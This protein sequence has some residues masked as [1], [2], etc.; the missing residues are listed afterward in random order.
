MS[1]TKYT[2]C[3]TKHDTFEIQIE[4]CKILNT[5]CN[6]DFTW[7]EADTVICQ[8]EDAYLRFYTQA[9]FVQYTLTSEGNTKT[10]T[11][12]M[13][14]IPTPQTDDIVTI[15]L[16]NLEGCDTMI[17]VGIHVNPPLLIAFL[18]VDSVIC[19]DEVAQLSLLHQPD[20]LVEIFP[21][22]LSWVITNP[23]WP[24]D[25][26][27]IS[28]DTTLYVRI[29][30]PLMS[31]D[32]FFTW[33]IR[34]DD[35]Q[36]VNFDTI[37]ICHGDSLEIDNQWYSTDTLIT[38]SYTRIGCDSLHHTQIQIRTPLQAEI[39]IQAP[40]QVSNGSLTIHMSSGVAPFLYSIN[41]GPTQGEP[42]FS[43]LAEGTFTITVKDDNGCSLDTT[44]TLMEGI[45]NSGLTT[46]VLN[47]T[48]DLDNGS[49]ILHSTST[50]IFYSLNGSTFSIDSAY[51]N[52]PEGHYSIVAMHAAGCMDTIYAD[53]VQT[54]K[55]KILDIVSAPAH[56]GRSDGSILVSLIEGGVD[57]YLI[58][59]NN[60]AF[61]TLT[62]FLN[63]VTGQYTIYIADSVQCTLDTS[64]FISHLS[65]PVISDISVKP[66][67]CGLPQ[68]SIALSVVDTNFLTCPI[69]N[70]PLT[71][72]PIFFS[73]LPGSYSLSVTDSAGCSVVQSV[74]VPDSFSFT[75]EMIEI[76]DAH[77]AESDGS[78]N[79]HVSGGLINV[80]IEELPGQTFNNDINGLLE[81]NYHLQIRD[82]WMCTLDTVIQVES[83]CEIYLPNVFSPNGDGVNDEFGTV[84]G[85]SFDFW[86]LLIFDRGGNMVFKSNDPIA[87]WNGLFKEVIV[88]SG[89][90]AW[91]LEYQLTKD[92]IH[93]FKK[94]DLALIR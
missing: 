38:S 49:I 71:P 94:G 54:G 76:K 84:S 50:D 13:L 61:D 6:I 62:H 70:E 3:G 75:L 66:A 1:V 67:L 69:N 64:I 86:E 89:V 56:C 27:P 32:S 24:L 73:L 43:Q 18:E 68:G 58:G 19:I 29:R 20:H 45:W 30:D 74:V 63:L 57:P 22:D 81:G 79:L 87:G 14:V 91:R 82:E 2:A 40:C 33:H 42:Y 4:P 31:C 8:G 78:I 21:P 44:I 39:N 48:C 59:L 77:C 11:S 88:Q 15:Y 23:A 92:P 53:L 93:K 52:L 47:A 17:T 60:Q 7:S 83:V 16:S 41:G 85:M 12:P 90:Y 34:V 9:P 5:S 72:E 10:L 25:F 37:F 65:G 35:I 36:P 51:M 55:P 26:G 28:M 80:S 46:D